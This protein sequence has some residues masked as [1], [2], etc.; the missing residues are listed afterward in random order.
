MARNPKKA[1]KGKRAKKAKIQDFP[2][3]KKAKGVK[4]GLV[5]VGISGIPKAIA[6]DVTKDLK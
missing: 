6:A 1:T 2:A 5:I 3:G 4:G